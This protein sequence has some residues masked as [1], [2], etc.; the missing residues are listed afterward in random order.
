MTP[1]GLAVHELYIRD[2][3]NDKPIV[4]AYDSNT[5]NSKRKNISPPSGVPKKTKQDPNAF[6]QTR[7]HLTAFDVPQ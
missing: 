3:F 4:A 6:C 5:N 2:H 7:I 1:E